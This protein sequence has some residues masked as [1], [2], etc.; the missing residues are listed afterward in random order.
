ML[1][2]RLLEILRAYW[3]QCGQDCGCFRDVIP[4]TM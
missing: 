4:A 1:S 3:K 2:P